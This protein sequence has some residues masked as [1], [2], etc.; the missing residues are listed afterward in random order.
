MVIAI[1]EEEEWNRQAQGAEE[2]KL[3]ER[4]R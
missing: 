1:G 4:I 3:K 2:T